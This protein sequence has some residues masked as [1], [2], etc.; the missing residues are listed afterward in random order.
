MFKTDVTGL[1]DESIYQLV[2]FTRFSVLDV[3]GH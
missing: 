1:T 3:T 2:S